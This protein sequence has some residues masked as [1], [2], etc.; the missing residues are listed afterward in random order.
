MPKYNANE[1]KYEYECTDCF[2]LRCFEHDHCEECGEPL[3]EDCA[4]VIDDRPLCTECCQVYLAERLVKARREKLIAGFR[5]LHDETM[6]M[7]E[8]A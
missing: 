3:C 6:H 1:L 7:L 2:E 8:V 5:K 4:R